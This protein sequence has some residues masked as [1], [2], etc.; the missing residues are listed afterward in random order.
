MHL[1]YPAIGTVVAEGAAGAAG[2]FRFVP[3]K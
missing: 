2:G 3:A 1:A